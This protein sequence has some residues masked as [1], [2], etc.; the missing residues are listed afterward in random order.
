MAQTNISIRIDEDVKRDAETL[1]DKIG[2]TLSAVTNVF[3]R[4][5]IR[6]QGIPFHITATEQKNDG[7]YLLRAALNE[8]QKQS[9]INGTS[10]M[11]PDEINDI[12]AE[13]RR[14]NK[15]AK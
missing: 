11:L 15:V 9:V 1:C 8:A 13:V 12:I 2:L 3:Y 14:E 4:Q 10:D 7:G 6:T 5:F